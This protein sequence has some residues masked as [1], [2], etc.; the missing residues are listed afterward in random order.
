MRDFW[1]DVN[2]LYWSWGFLLRRNDGKELVKRFDEK[3]SQQVVII[4]LLAHACRG[5]CTTII[6]EFQAGISLLLTTFGDLIKVALVVQQPRAACA[7]YARWC[8]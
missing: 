3:D 8:H 7:L 2:L 4:R 1:W 5:C 6:P